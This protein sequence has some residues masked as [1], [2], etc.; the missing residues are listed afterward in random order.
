MRGFGWLWHW[1]QGN[2]RTL[3]CLLFFSPVERRQQWTLGWSP[4]REDTQNDLSDATGPLAQTLHYILRD[5][6]TSGP[7]K[8]CHFSQA[9]HRLGKQARNRSDG[10]SCESATPN[11]HKPLS[12]FIRRHAA[13]ATNC[14][15]GAWLCPASLRSR[16]I[17]FWVWWLTLI[18]SLSGSG[19]SM[20]TNVCMCLWGDFWAGLTAVERA[21]LNIGSTNQW[22][23]LDWIKGESQLQSN[24]LFSPCLLTVADTLWAAHI[25]APMPSPP[26][27]TAPFN[28]DQNKPSHLSCWCEGFCHTSNKSLSDFLYGLENPW[29]RC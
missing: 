7:V 21:T 14:R 2:G 26:Q 17:Q 4:N 1:K 9:L 24:L 27:W 29:V 15:S 25:P 28:G 5:F 10:L 22:F 20:E 18:T 11:C 6:M 3:T 23:V 16:S 8:D 12:L 13:P 19:T